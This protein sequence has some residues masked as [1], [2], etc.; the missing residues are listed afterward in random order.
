MSC[1]KLKKNTELSLTKAFIELKRRIREL[2]LALK[3]RVN[4]LKIFLKKIT[5]TW[6]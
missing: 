3:N 5:I 6:S 4:S 2:F 1:T